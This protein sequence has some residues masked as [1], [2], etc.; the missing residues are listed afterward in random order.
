MRVAAAQNRK[1][2]GVQDT[3]RHW[4][5][6]KTCVVILNFFNTMY[7]LIT[8]AASTIVILRDL[9]VTMVARPMFMSNIIL[10]WYHKSQYDIAFIKKTKF[11][12][13]FM[14]NYL[15]VHFT[16]HTTIKSTTANTTTT[17]C[18]TPTTQTTPGKLT[19]SFERVQTYKLICMLSGILRFIL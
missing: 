15:N 10:V 8:V 11:K 19:T 12:G 5:I 4:K 16:E 6:A 17:T 14:Q 18:T 2:G 7:H 3:Q 13:R 1:Y 9:P